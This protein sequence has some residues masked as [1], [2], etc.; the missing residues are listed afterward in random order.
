MVSKSGITAEGVPK[1]LGTKVGGMVSAHDELW[2][3][4]QGS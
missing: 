3:G 1:A 4:A 2:V